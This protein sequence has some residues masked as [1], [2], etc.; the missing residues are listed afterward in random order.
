MNQKKGRGRPSKVAQVRM[1]TEK[2]TAMLENMKLDG[3]LP[4]I[5]QDTDSEW[6]NAFRDTKKSMIIR[7]NDRLWDYYRR[8]C[9]S[10]GVRDGLSSK[11]LCDS[12]KDVIKAK[13]DMRGNYFNL[14]DVKIPTMD[15]EE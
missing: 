10:V 9:Q 11:R 12:L 4:K 15:E 5:T 1:T 14:Q 7:T 8:W 3:W 2:A 13:H 6:D